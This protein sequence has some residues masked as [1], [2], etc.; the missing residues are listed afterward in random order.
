MAHRPAVTTQF[1]SL[2]CLAALLAACSPAPSP[3]QARDATATARPTVAA[4]SSTV[5]VPVTPTPSPTEAASPSSS[6]EPPI[7]QASATAFWDATHGV[8]GLTTWSQDGAETQGE[9]RTTADGGHTWWSGI[10][11]RSGVGEIAVAGSGAAWVLSRCAS[12]SAGCESTL[13][14][15]QDGGR[16]WDE[17]ATDVTQVSFVDPLDGWGVVGGAI[18]TDPAT[19]SLRRTADGGR[20]WS[21]MTDPC[22]GL[23][24]WTIRAAGFRDASNG[25][26]VCALTAGAGGELHAVL[27]TSDAGRHWTLRSSTGEPEQ[28]QPVGQ[29]PYSGYITTIAFTADGTAWLSG[30]RMAVEA[31]RDD[32]VTWRVLPV[33]GDGQ[34]SVAP[35]P[36]DRTLGFAVTDDPDG[37]GSILESTSN[38]GRT[39]TVRHR[40]EPDGADGPVQSNTPPTYLGDLSMDASPAPAWTGDA[41]TFHITTDP[42]GGGSEIFVAW[43]NVDFGD[44]TTK[45]L[46]GS[47]AE[48]VDVVHVYHR[49][50][51]FVP[52]VTSAGG[53]DAAKPVDPSMA[54]MPVRVYATASA[55]ERRWP[56]CTVAQVALDSPGSRKAFGDAAT[57]VVIRNTSRQ[58]CTLAG[59][60]AVT[61]LAAAS[62]ALPTHWRRATTG[63]TLSPAVTPHVVALGPGEAAVFEVG[64]TEDPGTAALT[65]AASCPAST[66]MR[67]GLPGSVASTTVRVLSRPCGGQ[68]AVSPVVSGSTALGRP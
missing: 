32:G 61:L 22:P 44:G 17:W 1:S 35:W 3:T 45:H 41:V 40:F 56:A 66:A 58:G 63:T 7:T 43:V 52:H 48:G 46:V 36:L 19:S 64:W 14:N 10:P 67:V 23:T 59:Y 6:P 53:C 33:G 30:D 47:C 16:T 38:G 37:P 13:Y 28:T 29:L 4:P 68:I 39:W 9:I 5:G 42:T 49:A 50:G 12:D 54:S 26:L 21:A 24:G 18:S 60:P 31:S 15:T 57:S 20:T 62:R 55:G 8:V 27:S 25:L 2:I 51:R 34:A 11:I 65:Y